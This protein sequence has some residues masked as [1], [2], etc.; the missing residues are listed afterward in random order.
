MGG[1]AVGAGA[2]L[3]GVFI[4]HF[5]TL[6]RER[7]AD[8]MATLDRAVLALVA[9]EHVLAQFIAKAGTGAPQP[10]V[11]QAAD[12]VSEQE[13]AMQAA[14]LS[15]S[16]RLGSFDRLLKPLNE[17]EDH[18]TEAYMATGPALVEGRQG[19]QTVAP[20]EEALERFKHAREEAL[21]EAN[22]R[23]GQRSKMDGQ[24]K[25]EWR[26]APTETVR[27]AL[28]S[29]WAEVWWPAFTRLFR[30]RRRLPKRG[31]TD[32]RTQK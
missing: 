6:R 10:V 28:A 32:E 21:S 4:G 2:A 26:D 16:V 19:P 15:L 9:G 23:F 20:A 12:A 18:Y 25:Q 3:V 13:V 5:L 30:R 29:M 27:E 8:L 22:A 1:I 24:T 17:A 7:R 14:F 31:A 11:Q